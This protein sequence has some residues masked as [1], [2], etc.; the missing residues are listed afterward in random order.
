[1]T[2]DVPAALAE[3]LA[4]DADGWIVSC[5]QKL[6]PGDRAGEKYRIKLK[7]RLRLAGERLGIL[8][9]AHSEREAI[10]DALARIEDFFG[11]PGNL[12]AARGLAVFVGS[13]LF[14]VVRLPYVLRSRVLVDR[15]PVVSELVALTEAGTS[16]LVAVADRRSARLFAVGLDGVEELEGVVAPG[17]TRESRFHGA[18]GSAPGVGEYRFHNRIREE[19]HRHLAGAAEAV[20]R[21][22]RQRAFD[23]LVVGGIGADD[24]ALLPHLDSGVRDKVIGVLRLAPRNVSASE[25]RERALALLAEA[26]DTAAAEAVGEVAGLRTGGWATDGVEPTLRALARGQVRTLLVDNDVVL[27]GYRLQ[28]SGRLTT[29]PGG[30]RGE[31]EPLPVADVLDDAIEEALRQRARVLV[32]SGAL[33][34]RID[35]LAALLRFRT[36]K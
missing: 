15:T 8:G 21:A 20:S 6:E 18:R 34:K 13:R 2:S 28:S 17:S 10:A 31:G 24:A 33:A 12:E 32:V 5:Y 27:P 35:R 29:V 26:A 16:L 30:P 11:H 3:L 4:W 1:V 7:N 25:I 22:F 19:K 14:L 36:G 9:F 23:G